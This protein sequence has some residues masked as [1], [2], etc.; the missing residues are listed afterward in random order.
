[1]GNINFDFGH[2]TIIYLN[3]I[4]KFQLNYKEEFLSDFRLKLVK[5]FPE[6]FIFLHSEIEINKDKESEIKLKEI[7]S[8]FDQIH[9]FSQT[10][11]SNKEKQEK[12]N[13]EFDKMKILEK[14][15]FFSIYEYPQSKE[16]DNTYYSIVLYG[17][18]SENTIFI[19]GFL[20]FLF[21]VELEDNYRFKL[22]SI[23]NQN[24]NLIQVKNI[25]SFKGNF[26]FKC[27]NKEYLNENGIEE[28]YEFFN[29]EKSFNSF[30]INKYYSGDIDS[31]DFNYY[32]YFN[33]YTIYYR[34]LD[35]SMPKNDKEKYYQNFFLIAADKYNFNHPFDSNFLTIDLNKYNEEKTIEELHQIY[36]EEIKKSNERLINEFF[37]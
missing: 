15:N 9:L 31:N 10:L 33:E 6:D 29:K 34:Y 28:I 19:N 24:N 26:S 32:N 23:E 3:G 18:K 8:P 22:E 5:L 35:K 4:P 37:F 14:N 17:S 1:M 21:N 25:K 16:N 36:K 11:Y 2:F 7:T 20:N 27:I 30:I 13:L 12:I